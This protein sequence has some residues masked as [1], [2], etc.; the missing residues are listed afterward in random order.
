MVARACADIV[1]LAKGGAY[2]A[3]EATEYVP[4]AGAARA[5]AIRNY[6]AALAKGLDESQGG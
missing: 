4:Q 6:E 5:S 2:E 3:E 1:R